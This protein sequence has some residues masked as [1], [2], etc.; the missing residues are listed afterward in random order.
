MMTRACPALGAK[1]SDL[2]HKHV[3]LARGPVL[4]LE[5]GVLCSLFRFSPPRLAL[6]NRP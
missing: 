5:R 1:E 4:I 2:R 3:L 6:N